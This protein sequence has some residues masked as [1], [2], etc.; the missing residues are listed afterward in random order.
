M[1]QIDE[2]VSAAPKTSPKASKPMHNATPKSPS[3][4]FAF[5]IDSANGR[6]VA[7]EKVD[8]ETR[9]MLS[10][11][12]RTKL[13]KDHGAVALRNLVEQAFEAGIDFVLGGPADEDSAQS[14]PEGEL[15]GVLLKS[16]FEGSKARDM[17]ATETLDRAVVSTLFSNAGKSAPPAH[18]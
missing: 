7:I 18:R 12:E 1:P 2:P 14:K 3:G 6:V 4:L 8:G 11:E 9:E 16:M 13:A 17:V 5:T 10:P 15:S